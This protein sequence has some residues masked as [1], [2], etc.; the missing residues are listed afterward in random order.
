MLA[1]EAFQEEEEEH[2]IVVIVLFLLEYYTMAVSFSVLVCKS[3][4]A[5]VPIECCTTLTVLSA[6]SVDGCVVCYSSTAL[7][8]R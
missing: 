3:I 8:F 2:G 7:L 6:S 5:A 4:A 1:C